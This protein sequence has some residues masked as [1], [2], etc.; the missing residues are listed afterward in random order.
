ML[1]KDLSKMEQV[2]VVVCFVKNDKVVEGFLHFT[3]ADGLDAESLFATIKDT[4]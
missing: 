1:S 3:P 4:Q 2:S